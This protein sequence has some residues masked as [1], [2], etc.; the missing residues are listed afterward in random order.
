MTKRVLLGTAVGFGFVALGFAAEPSLSPSAPAGCVADGQNARIVVD[1]SKTA[2]LHSV[3]LYFQAQGQSPE[4][5]VEMRMA[6][7]EAWAVLPRVAAGTSEILFRARAIDQS[8]REVL[9]A[10]GRV[11]VTAACPATPLSAEQK[12]YASNLVVG[13]TVESQATVPIGFLCDGIVSSIAS[14]GDM[15]SRAACQEVAA[16]DPRNLRGGISS[17]GSGAAAQSTAL[18]RAPAPAVKPLSAARP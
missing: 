4:S 14:N 1:L 15:R 16:A 8:G 12:A 18:K 6:G 2:R 17:T 7:N 3:R 10:P 13:Q 9:G 5:Y 11:P